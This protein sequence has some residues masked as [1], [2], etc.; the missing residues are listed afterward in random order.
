MFLHKPKNSRNWHVCG[1]VDNGKRK[2]KALH[3]YLNLPLPVRDKRQAEK[4]LVSLQMKAIE[5]RILGIPAQPRKISIEA[6]YHEY[7][8]YCDR[9]KKKSTAS[10]N[11]YQLKHWLQFLKT[12]GIQSPNQITRQLVNAFRAE[13]SGRTN[14]TINHYTSII[15]A[16]LRWGTD[17]DYLSENPLEH[18]RRLPEK[19]TMVKPSQIEPK[20]LQRLLSVSDEKFKLFIQILYWT[21]QRKSSILALTWT[22]ID[23]KNRVITFRETKS[24]K[25]KVI[26]IAPKLFDVLKP[27]AHQNGK[28]FNWKIDYVTRKFQRLRDRLN[29]KI[30]GIHQF[31]HARASELLRRGE[32]PRTV[33]ELL[34]HSTAHTTLGIYA[35]VNL[36][37]LRKALER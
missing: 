16:S 2:C 12:R 9:N 29:L 13:L 33:Q 26:P 31:R 11:K 25:S 14:R 34:G 23:F 1:I 36:D 17:E 20:D 35:Q 22:D 10:S 4:L 21:F 24:G 32:N 3:R 15:R 27:I 18:Y 8:K 5:E 19:T 28:L 37:D 6:F 7:S 30:K